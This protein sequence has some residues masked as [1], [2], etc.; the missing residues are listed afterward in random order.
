[1]KNLLKII[2]IINKLKEPKEKLGE[3]TAQ[4]TGSGLLR[5]AL[6]LLGGEQ[7]EKHEQH[8]ID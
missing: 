1:M 6:I 2:I 5:I 3:I 7:D 4:P 8:E